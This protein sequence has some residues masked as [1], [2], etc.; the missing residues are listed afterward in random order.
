MPRLDGIIGRYRRRTDQSAPEHTEEKVLARL[1]DRALGSVEAVVALPLFR[2]S[3]V[4]AGL[5]IGLL[6]IPLAQSTY[7]APET[8]PEL[9]V[10]APHS[11]YLVASILGQ[12]E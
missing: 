10:F 6:S 2:P 12:S 11:P 3:A 1:Q 4:A 8:L 7:A 5:I 9:A